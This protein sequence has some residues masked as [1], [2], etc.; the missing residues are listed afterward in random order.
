MFSL[1]GSKRST[2]ALLV[3]LAFGLWTGTPFSFHPPTSENSSS[4]LPQLLKAIHTAIVKL[5]MV[6]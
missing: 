2:P 3:L 1:D 5:A 4:S 6:I